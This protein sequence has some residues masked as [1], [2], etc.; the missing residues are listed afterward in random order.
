MN[1]E[2]NLRVSF[3]ERK[4]PVLYLNTGFDEVRRKEGI[5]NLVK[6]VNTK[7]NNFVLYSSLGLCIFNKLEERGTFPSLNFLIGV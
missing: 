5:L 7:Y 1:T 4:R 6:I 2:S 3:M